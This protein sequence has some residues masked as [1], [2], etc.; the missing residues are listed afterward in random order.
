MSILKDYQAFGG[1]HYETG[2]LHNL[3]AY[4]GDAISEALLMG[5]SGGITV[6]YFSFAYEGYDPHVAVLTRNTFDPFRRMLERIGLVQ[7]VLQST[8]EDKARANLIDLLESGQAALAWVDMYRLPWFVSM[9]DD[10]MTMMIP[11]VV[12]GY[13]DEKAFL[14]DRSSVP[15]EMAAA[16]FDAARGSVKKERYRLLAVDDLYSDRLPSGIEQGLHD[17][18]SLFTG[19]VPVKQA[20]KSMGYAGMT[21][22][23]DCL[24]KRGDRQSWVKVFPAGAPMFAGLTT[25]FS[26]IEIQNGPGAERGRFADFLDEAAAR[27]QRPALKEVAEGYR[28]LTP[29]WSALAEAHLPESVPLFAE[30]R[31][32]MVRESQ[33]F[34]EQ[35][36]SAQGERE[37]IASR[38]HEI[39]SIV[40]DDFPLSEAEAADLRDDLAGRVLDLRDK[41]QA[42]IEALKQVMR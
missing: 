28:A 32:L 12:Y 24:S 5:I 26:S 3:L 31:E 23:A 27:I 37:Q 11:V 29:E 19:D 8:N 40:A 13:A 22:W 39:R 33:L 10:D 9:R 4:R 17:T 25:S 7:N 35:G 15:L 2:S 1:R 14:A 20:A 21:R 30:A 36:M 41:E 18:I 16:D 42:Q 38:L 6:G 34:I